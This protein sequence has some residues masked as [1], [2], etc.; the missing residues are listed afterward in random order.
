M[1]MRLAAE[2]RLALR[3]GEVEADLLPG[4]SLRLDH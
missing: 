4:E 3:D 1:V 2:G